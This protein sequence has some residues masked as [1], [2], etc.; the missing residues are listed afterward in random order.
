M[1]KVTYEDA[2]SELA[3]MFPGLTPELLDTVL[4]QNSIMTFH[5]YS[6]TT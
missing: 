3:V 1:S 4:R 5:I 2:M 6:G